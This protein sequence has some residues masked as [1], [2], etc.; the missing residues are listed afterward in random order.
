MPL[1]VRDA[2]ARDGQSEQEAERCRADGEAERVSTSSFVLSI[3]CSGTGAVA[4]GT[5]PFPV[6]ASTAAIAPYTTV[7]IS[8]ASQSAMPMA[9]PRSDTAVFFASFRM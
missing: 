9:G 2:P 7:A 6:S 3:A 5:L 4:Y 1:L 8:A